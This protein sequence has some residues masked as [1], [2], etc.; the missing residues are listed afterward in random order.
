VNDLLEEIGYQKQDKI[1]RKP[2]Q[3]R[4]QNTPMQL[5][6]A[7]IAFLNG[8]GTWRVI[9]GT[10]VQAGRYAKDMPDLDCPVFNLDNV[11]EASK[12]YAFSKHVD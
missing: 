10:Q 7:Q 4:S 11:P 8:D 2:I 9:R 5:Q 6:E 1:P 12:S 3:M